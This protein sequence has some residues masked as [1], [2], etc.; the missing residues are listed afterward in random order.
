MGGRE[1]KT[2]VVAGDPCPNEASRQSFKK[3]IQGISGRYCR[4]D[5]GC[6]DLLVMSMSTK[7]V[8]VRDP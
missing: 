7:E 3:F 1:S 5:K 8:H 4:T 6:S 2:A